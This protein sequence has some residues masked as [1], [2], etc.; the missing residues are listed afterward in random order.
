MRISGTLVAS[1][2]ALALVAYSGCKRHTCDAGATQPCLCS[3]LSTSAQVCADDGSRWLTCQCE[4]ITPGVDG[5]SRPRD[6]GAPGPMVTCAPPGPRDLA[7]LDEPIS[8]S[9]V[10]DADLE[11]YSGGALARVA[12][13]ACMLAAD[14]TTPTPSLCFD[15][16][17]CGACTVEISYFMGDTGPLRRFTGDCDMFRGAYSLCALSTTC[18]GRNCGEDSCGRSC[19]PTCPSGMSCIAGVCGEPP[20]P[21]G[22]MQG[23]VCCGPPF[24]AGDCVGTPC[25]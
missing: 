2:S 21:S 8:P 3:D 5:G 9:A 4:G 24:C 1:A 22:C 17:V 18:D 16:Y 14:Q 13:V 23:S 6:A 7:Q 19:G 15:R 25:C 12:G 20:C 10:A 11:Y